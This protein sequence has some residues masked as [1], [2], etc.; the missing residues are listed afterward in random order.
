MEKEKFY[1]IIKSSENSSAFDMFQIKWD[2]GNGIIERRVIFEG[3][4]SIDKPLLHLEDSRDYL[5]INRIGGYDSIKSLT[6]IHSDNS[7]S[8]Y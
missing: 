5:D 7:L 4:D 3:F 8:E 2:R 1:E 6:R